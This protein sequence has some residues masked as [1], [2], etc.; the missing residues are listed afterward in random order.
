MINGDEQPLA[1]PSALA[2]DGAG[3]SVT[4]TANSPTGPGR[5]SR[6]VRPRRG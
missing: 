2:D 5:G 6:S 3:F 4:R 1:A